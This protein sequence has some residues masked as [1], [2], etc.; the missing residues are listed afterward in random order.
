MTVDVCLR[1][2]TVDYFNRFLTLVKNVRLRKY[3]VFFCLVTSLC[4][5]YLM[6]RYNNSNVLF[7][8]KIVQIIHV[9][10]VMTGYHKQPSHDTVSSVE[11]L[12]EFRARL[13]VRLNKTVAMD[14]T[15]VECAQIA[16]E[17]RLAWRSRPSLNGSFTADADHAWMTLVRDKC[18]ALWLPE[19]LSKPPVPFL[20]EFEKMYVLD[21][22][23]ENLTQVSS[24][25]SSTVILLNNSQTFTVG[26]TIALR[27]E[28]KDQEGQPKV[29]GGDEM[30][31]WFQ[32]LDHDSK[33][34]G[35]VTDLNNGTYLVTAVLPWEGRLR[36]TIHL[37]YSREFFTALLTSHLM[38]KGYK[39]AVGGFVSSQAS[40]ATLCHNTDVLPGYTQGEVC[41]LTSS[42]GSPWYCGRPVKKELNCSH[43]IHTRF[44]PDTTVAPLTDTEQTIL[45]KKIGS[46][47]INYDNKADVHFVVLN[48]T[49]TTGVKVDTTPDRLIPPTP[50]NQV[51]PRHTWAQPEPTGY[52]YKGHWQP[53]LCRVK[54]DNSSS[55]FKNVSFLLLGDSNGRSHYYIIAKLSGCANVI[56]ATS[57]KWHK[58]LLCV[59]QANNFSIKWLPHS[60]PFLSYSTEWSS[61][62]K[63]LIP[64][65]Y[66]IDQ[67]PM[68][69]RHIVYINHYIHLTSHHLSAYV[70]MMTDI[71]LA[72]D[73]LIQRNP[74]V[75]VV[76]QGPHV[77]NRKS[78]Y[79]FADVV[80]PFMIEIQRDVFKDLQDHVIYLPV[81]DMSIACQNQDTHPT[82]PV[83][84]ELAKVLLGLICDRW[85]QY[86]T[87][88]VLVHTKVVHIFHVDDVMKS[89]ETQPSHDTVSSV[90]KLLEFRARLA[91]RL[92]KTVA[93]DATKVECAQ[94]AREPRLAWRSRPSLN[95][96][97]TADADHAW[98]TLVR[99]KCH[100]LWLPEFLS[101]PPVPFL[102]EFEKL[103]VL[104]PPI[105]NLTQVS[106]HKSSTVILLNN[107]QTF[108]VGDTIAL[109]VEV[110]D[111]EGQPKVKGGDEIRAWFQDLD[112]DSKLAGQVTDL[113]NGT[114]LVTA[115]L[116]WEGRLRVTVQ[117]TYSREFFTALLTSHLMIK[118]FRQTVGGFV[119]SQ[120][121]EA[122]LCHNTDVLPGYTQGEVCNLTSSNGSPWYCGRPVKTE[123]NCSHYIHTRFLP[124]AAVAPITDTE[125]TILEKKMGSG[126]ISTD[127][128][129]LLVLKRKDLKGEKVDPT[130]DR[131]I[132]PTPCNQVPPRHTWAQ[133][134]P[135]GYFYKGHWQPLLC[136]VK[137]D[138]SNSCFKNVSFLLLG[139]S[140]G[141][142]HYYTITSLSGCA[143]VISATSKKWHK[144]LLC[145]HKA[146]N[147]SIKWLPHS[148][149]FQSYSTEWSSPLKDLIPSS[150]A[151]DQIPMTGR[152]IVYINHYIHLT[153]HHLS[154]YVNMMTDIKLAIDRLIQ[155]NPN[156]LVVL[157]GPHIVTRQSVYSFADVVRPFMIEI[158]RDVFKDLQDHVIYLPVSD[159]S[160][161]CQN[162]DTH[163]IY[164]VAEDIT[165][166]L[167]GTVCDRW[168]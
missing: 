26:D 118:G 59:H 85:Q 36:V 152:H 141:R 144:P 71:K 167:L 80:R 104:D 109:R 7:I 145:V 139:D 84:L 17:P 9:G 133:P 41:N 19:F 30:R 134:E 146:N 131:L 147:F 39:Q 143:D 115:V 160:I 63:D 135:T 156:V 121:S 127:R 112:H 73:R 64:S 165:K 123:L 33:L 42:N 88:T 100:A 110:K 136:R 157:Q 168:K 53:L 77:A 98:M 54:E 27:V 116:P 58:P 107:S 166:V 44:L 35:Q 161:A 83:R 52:F 142:S 91:F 120:A 69:G 96:S 2:E 12:L 16:R 93:M 125:Q 122:T 60:N 129:Q 138:N 5:G 25:K 108:T 18:H 158:Q 150:Y 140:N 132:P 90:E 117:L 10:D 4:L 47:F 21:P 23:I 111:Q 128:F 149:P 66:A 124:D 162:Q 68:T 155:R 70:N 15:K 105:E 38:I 1:N 94:I 89:G 3:F 45:Q 82:I 22:P 56:N 28:V 76:L 20:Y 49:Q 65:S 95:G 50:C 24:H 99:D 46:G 163:P 79:S 86:D 126:F 97:F 61:P 75:I 11:K 130:P 151:I 87:P 119:N 32:D 164:K 51:P 48:R 55:C 148:N 137:G 37:A 29:K 40:E 113:N 114:Y 34:A 154:A 103:Y 6:L 101:K 31:A 43:Y 102:Y 106:S 74:N 14:A 67:I 57:E 153:S 92:N 62:L 72:I 13:A 8:D 159:M 81:S 78:A